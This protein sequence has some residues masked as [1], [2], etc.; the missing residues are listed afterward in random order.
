MAP[1]VALL[2]LYLGIF[3]FRTL[4]MGKGARGFCMVQTAAALLIGFGGAV[5]LAQAALHKPLQDARCLVIGG[6]DIAARKIDM[7]CRAGADVTVLAPEF[8]AA[9]AAR[10]AG[11]DEPFDPKPPLV[12]IKT[13]SLPLTVCP[14][15]AAPVETIADGERVGWRLLLA[16][17]SL[18]ALIDSFVDD[19]PAEV[20][21][22]ALA[23]GKLREPPVNRTAVWNRETA[24]CSN[25][26][27]PMM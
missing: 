17:H 20:V 9:V 15:V 19:L 12:R 16:T 10:L 13:P 25:T 5:R 18:P 2:L 22:S 6:G 24:T 27:A 3:S 14:P 8:A 1:A 11:L 7:L 26:H 21:F 4:V 23:D